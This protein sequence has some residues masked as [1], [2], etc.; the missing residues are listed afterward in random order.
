VGVQMAR[1]TGCRNGGP[2]TACLRW[3][4]TYRRRIVS[5][6][7]YAR[8]RRL[9]DVCYL[10]AFAALTT[11][12]PLAPAPS[13]ALSAPPATPTTAPYPPSPAASSASDIA[14]SATTPPTTNT[15]PGATAK[16]SPLDQLAQ[17]T[18][19]GIRIGLNFS[20]TTG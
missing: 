14:V 15:P 3:R 5:L 19:I 11:R 1:N 4:F 12:A 17:G 18:S 13:M 2:A 16:T 9:A 7:R 6:A 10:W 8:N 20:R